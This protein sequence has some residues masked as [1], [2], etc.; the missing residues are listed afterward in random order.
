VRFLREQRVKVPK[1]RGSRWSK[2]WTAS[3]RDNDLLSKHARWI[4]NDLLD[5]IVYNRGKIAAVEGRLRE[6][7]END[8]VIAKLMQQMGSVR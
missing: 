2:A 6:A 5:D 4:V 7:A 8:G 3:V 1:D